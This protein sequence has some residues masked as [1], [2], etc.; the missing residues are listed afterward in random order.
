MCQGGECRCVPDGRGTSGLVVQSFIAV[1][2]E[3]EEAAGDVLDDGDFGEPAVVGGGG[4]FDAAIREVIAALRI[5]KECD[6]M[7][8][9]KVK[10]C[11]MGFNWLITGKPRPISES[12]H[13][14]QY[15]R[16]VSGLTTF[17]NRGK[18]SV[19]LH[20][21][22]CEKADRFGRFARDPSISR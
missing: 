21:G 19:G 22:I 1:F 6:R 16:I 10:D 8:A 12:L 20:G 14:S 13:R 4:E 2:V 3:V 5:G 18:R 9:Q 7:G 17:E 15:P 11:G